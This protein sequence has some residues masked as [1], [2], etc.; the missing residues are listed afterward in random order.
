ML[1][2]LLVRPDQRDCRNRFACRMV[3][4]LKRLWVPPMPLN[5][6]DYALVHYIGK[7]KKMKCGLTRMRAENKV[8]NYHFVWCKKSFR[9]VKIEKKS[10]IGLTWFFI[11]VET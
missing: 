8:R 11:A 3:Y 1:L 7:L 5:L 4:F 2:C 9:V 6:S 10:D